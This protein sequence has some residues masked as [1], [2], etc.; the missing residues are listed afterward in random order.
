METKQEFEMQKEIIIRKV[1]RA[2][3]RIKLLS[4]LEECERLLERD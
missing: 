1:K 4:A 3:T 2:E